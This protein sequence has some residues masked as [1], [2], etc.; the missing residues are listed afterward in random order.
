VATV[1][2]H[3]PLAAL[4]SVA[5]ILNSLPKILRRG[6]VSQN[7]QTVDVG[8]ESFLPDQALL[9]RTSGPILVK[10]KAGLNKNILRW[11]FSAINDQ[12]RVRWFRAQ[13]TPRMS[14]TDVLELLQDLPNSSITGMDQST[15]S[16][17]PHTSCDLTAPPLIPSGFPNKY[18][19]IP[20]AIPGA[21]T[22]SKLRPI[23]VA[24]LEEDAR[25]TQ[26]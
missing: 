13:F 4:D 18:G 8:I 16:P 23:S 21:T 7:I 20:Y 15:A 1:H 11:Q 6:A 19:K 3:E 26:E 25:Q 5:T 9:D 17:I 2:S 12:N 10:N 22:L 24:S 14:K